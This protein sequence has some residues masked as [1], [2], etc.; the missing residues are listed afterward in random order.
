MSGM[1]VGDVCELFFVMDV[2]VCVF[3]GV[4]LI[5]L[6][7][8]W[9]GFFQQEWFGLFCCVKFVVIVGVF[10]NFVWV[11]YFV[12]MYLLLSMVYDVYLVNL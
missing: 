11:L 12:V 9:V 8:I 6:G 4:V 5:V 3:F 10:N 7:W 2:V 1:I